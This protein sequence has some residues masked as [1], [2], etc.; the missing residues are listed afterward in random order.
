MCYSIYV[1]WAQPLAPLQKSSIFCGSVC[2]FNA[3]RGGQWSIRP[4]LVADG[5]TD[6]QSVGRTDDW[7]WVWLWLCLTT[8]PPPPPPC[9]ST[10]HSV[11]WK[12]FITPFFPLFSDEVLRY[13]W[14]CR[15]WLTSFVLKLP[16]DFAETLLRLCREST[17]N[18]LRV[19]S[20]CTEILLRFC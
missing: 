2:K 6:R 19:C 17:E 5:P 1:G 10:T 12:L 13:I 3:L 18:P 7:L 11:H 14:F 4:T 20:D 15:L 8:I 16:W 9:F